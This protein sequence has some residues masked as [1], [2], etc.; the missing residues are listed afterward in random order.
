[1]AYDARTFGVH[2]E[3]KIKEWNLKYDYVPNFRISEMKN[4]DWAQVR[5]GEKNPWDDA[6]V[7]DY[8]TFMNAG[9]PFPPVVLWRP[10][11]ISDGNNRIKA[12]KLEGRRT[13]PAFVVDLPTTDIAQP[14]GAALNQLGGRRL[15][16]QQVV[17]HATSMFAQGMSDQAIASELGRSREQIR[18]IRHHLEFEKRVNDAKLTTVAAG[19]PKSQRWR[20]NQITNDPAFREA[21]QVVTEIKVTDS[22]LREM[23]DDAEAARTQEAAVQAVARRRETLEPYGPGRPK[24]T[25]GLGQTP[26]GH[27]LAAIGIL[28]RYKDE[29]AR[30]LDTS[31]E[32]RTK[33]AVAAWLEV[34]DLSLVMLNLYTPFAEEAASAATKAAA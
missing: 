13:F 5:I 33:K 21:I 7:A 24:Q 11:I 1:M 9:A 23:I 16:A 6:T 28:R 20:L 34:Y 18:R 29:P 19:I 4:A 8:R 31:T 25:M 3:H 26:P 22:D 10:N 12:A 14:F 32:E 30:M 2:F 17:I 15:T 27:A